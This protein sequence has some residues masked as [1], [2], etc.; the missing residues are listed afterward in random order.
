VQILVSWA[1][2]TLPQDVH[3]PDLKP[4]ALLADHLHVLREILGVHAST[5]ADGAP[6]AEEAAAFARVLVA[7]VNPA[8]EA[9][10]AAAAAAQK[11]RA[12]PGWAARVFGLKCLVAVGA[13]LGEHEF[14]GEKSREV[15]EKVEE[16]VKELIEEHVSPLGL[17]AEETTLMLI[18]VCGSSARCGSRRALRCRRQ[19]ALG[20]SLPG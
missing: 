16:Q 9:C 11:G 6:A 18:L 20:A 8:L 17:E 14:A 13:V 10:A 4:P 12:A 2:L 5:L 3:D 19:Q 1:R 7:G 15:E